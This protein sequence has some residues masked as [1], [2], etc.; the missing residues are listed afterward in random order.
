MDQPH[1]DQDQDRDQERD[2]CT[3]TLGLQPR[4]ELPEMPAEVRDWSGAG[5]PPFSIHGS[6]FSS[7]IQFPQVSAQSCFACFDV[8]LRAGGA[9]SG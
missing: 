9:L 7:K 3:L 4:A 8:L 6:D 5:G 1:Q 2:Q